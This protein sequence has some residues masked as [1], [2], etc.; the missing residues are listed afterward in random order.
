MRYSKEQVDGTAK[1]MVEAVYRQKTI[2]EAMEQVYSKEVKIYEHFKQN[3]RNLEKQLKGETPHLATPSNWAEAL[4]K[5]LENDDKLKFLDAMDRQVVYDANYGTP[6][7][8]LKKWIKAKRDL[9][10]LV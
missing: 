8:K 2:D 7:H 1:L 4:Y 10:Q 9:Q 5:Y 6:S 3:V